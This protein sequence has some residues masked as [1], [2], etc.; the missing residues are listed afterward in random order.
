MSADSNCPLYF[1]H[2]GFINRVFFM[3]RK[4][5]HGPN[6]TGSHSLISAV[7]L[8]LLLHVQPGPAWAP[9]TALSFRT[10]QHP[11]H[12][13]RGSESSQ[14]E[15]IYIPGMVLPFLVVWPCALHYL[16]PYRVFYSLKQDTTKYCLGPGTHL[17][18]RRCSSEHKTRGP[19]V[20]S[21]TKLL[22]NHHLTRDV[23]QPLE[24]IAKVPLWRRW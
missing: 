3:G 13:E 11:L 7:W 8:L 22:K 15:L 19:L 18:Q 10:D 5:P 14:L 21:C 17:Y 12:P 6:S 9:H 2:S 20:V 23:E 4:A 24:G 1:W 16:T